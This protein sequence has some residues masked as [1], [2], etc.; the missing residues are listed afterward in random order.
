MFSQGQEKGKGSAEAMKF[1]F[2]FS[3]YIEHHE[4]A[5][6]KTQQDWLGVGEILK[7]H[8][9]SVVEFANEEAAFQDAKYLSEKNSKEQSW[10]LAD[11][12][13]QIDEDKKIYSKFW[14][15]KCDGKVTTIEQD[16]CKK[17]EGASAAKNLKQVE[18][19]MQ[20]MEGLGFQPEI[21][22]ASIEYVSHSEL[23]LQLEKL[24]LT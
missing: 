24:K 10:D 6:W 1:H 18:E 20:F 3:G 2:E 15:Q 14:F 5:M 13:P 11:Y 7:L 17:L 21:A 12:P 22:G 4:K 16:Q 19:G 8:G 9:R 23:Q